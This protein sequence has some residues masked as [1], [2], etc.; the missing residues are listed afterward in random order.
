M[1]P[2]TIHRYLLCLLYLTIAHIAIGQNNYISVDPIKPVTK[3]FDLYPSYAKMRYS[4]GYER[5]LKNSFSAAALLNLG[6]IGGTGITESSFGE[7][8]SIFSG[9]RL[10]LQGRFYT[11][12]KNSE[13][14][15]KGSGFFL[16]PYAGF[17][18]GKEIVYSSISGK[19]EI[20]GH[21]IGFGAHGGYK[22]LIKNRISIEPQ[23]GFPLVSTYNG[24][25]PKYKDNF[26]TATNL[27]IGNLNVGYYF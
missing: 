9:M 4:V 18:T 10:I 23:L 11:A 25:N 5:L 19:K 22:F 12:G 26:L 8:I 27:W 2:H 7:E 1:K 3:F 13:R 24:F 21:V 14:F 6:Q 20:K 17:M 15:G 16:G